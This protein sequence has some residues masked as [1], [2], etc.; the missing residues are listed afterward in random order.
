MVFFIWSS[1]E[2][3]MNELNFDQNVF[4][5]A[6][7][8]TRNNYS[9]TTSNVTSIKNE[10]GEEMSREWMAT[11]LY[12]RTGDGFTQSITPRWDKIRLY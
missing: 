12:K 5:W 3:D 9:N 6:I 8:W 7:R 10:A 4:N 2:L 11:Y 1:S